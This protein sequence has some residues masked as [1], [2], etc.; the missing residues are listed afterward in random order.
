MATLT[1][2]LTGLALLVGLSLPA[3]AARSASEPGHAGEPAATVVEV[4]V[5]GFLLS[6]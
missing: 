3:Q 1:S 5:A 4:Q 2:L 6:E